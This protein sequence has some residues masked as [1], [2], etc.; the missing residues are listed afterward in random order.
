MES[1]TVSFLN[2]LLR[3]LLRPLAVF[4]QFHFDCDILMFIY[5][6]A[7]ITVTYNIFK[8]IYTDGV[9]SI[10]SPF[11]TPPPPPPRC[12]DGWRRILNRV[13]YRRCGEWMHDIFFLI[14]AKHAIPK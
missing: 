8:R 2:Q 7:T 14:L 1:S 13:M 4:M 12:A 3:S 6:T 10:F 9:D 11:Y 5:S